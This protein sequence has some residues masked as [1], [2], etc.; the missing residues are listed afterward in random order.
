MYV[1]VLLLQIKFSCING[2]T[3]FGTYYAQLLNIAIT[4]S[5]KS[6]V[7][8]LEKA[9]N[10]AG[11]T[12]LAP[13]NHKKILNYSKIYLLKHLFPCGQIIMGCHPA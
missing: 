11:F 6:K 3:G 10:P 2:Q 8:G 9:Q 12:I 7:K 4:C 5:R 1:N 13:T